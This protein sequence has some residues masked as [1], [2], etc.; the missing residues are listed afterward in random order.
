VS[1]GPDDD[2]PAMPIIRKALDDPIA[3][4]F[5]DVTLEEVVKQLSHLRRIPILVDIRALDD[6]GIGTDVLVSFH[7]GPIPLRDALRHILRQLD[8]TYILRDEALVI[9]TRGEAEVNLIARA[10]PVRDLMGEANAQNELQGTPEAASLDDLIE[11]I[12]SAVEV[13]TWDAVGG[14]GSIEAC[15]HI[16]VLVISQTGE[17]HEKVAD[18]LKKLR[19]HL[20]GRERPAATPAVTGQ[21]APTR[22]VVYAVPS[23]VSRTQ[24]AA[25]GRPTQAGENARPRSSVADRHAL[26]TTSNFT[27]RTA[28]GS[29]TNAFPGIGAHSSR[30]PTRLHVD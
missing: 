6:M 20:A 27:S 8:L 7:S 9:T 11:L 25:P 19:Q 18:L 29:W 2:D 30:A 12:T 22:L 4:E 17:C 23:R 28:L 26:S 21:P 13:Q 3:P 24:P 15:P 14:P 10:Y 1:V 16:D 5:A